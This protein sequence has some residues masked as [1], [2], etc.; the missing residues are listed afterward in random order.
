MIA[1]ILRFY[2]D[3]RGRSG[4]GR[5]PCPGTLGEYL[6]DRR[7]GREFRNHFLVPIT[8]AVWSTA[9]DRILDFPIDY[10]LHFLD[11]H[12][13]IGRHQA[14]QWRTITG[15]SQRYV[16][17]ILATL[18]ADA[19]RAGDPVVTVTRDDAGATVRTRDG[20]DGAVRRGRHGHPRG[21]HAGP[22]RRTRTTQERT[23]LGGFDYTTNEVVLHTDAGML[24]TKRRA[25]AS[26]NVEMPDCRSLG[27]ALTMTYHMNRLQ[28]LPGSVQYYVSVN[29][30]DRVDPA[31]RHH[32]AAH[33]PPDVHLPDARRPA[34]RRRA[35]GPAAHLV[36]RRAPGLRLPRGR[37]PLRLRSPRRRSARTWRG[38]PREI[39]PA[40]RARCATGARG[41]PC[42]RWSTTS[43]TPRWTST[44]CDDVAAL[45]APALAGTGPGLV[46][47]R[48]RDHL[49][50]P[51]TDLR[52]DLLAHLRAEGEDPTGWRILLV[53][54]LRVFG[55]VFNPASFY[56]C[57]DAAGALRVVIIEVHNTHGGRRLYTLRPGAPRRLPPGRDGQGLLRLAVHRHG[58]ALPR[59]WSATSPAGCGSS[60]TRTSTARRCWPRASTLTRLRL[61]DRNLARMLVRYPFVT[62]KTIGMIHWHALRLW[63]RGVTFHHHGEASR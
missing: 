53:T 9:P 19:V 26:W 55:Y 61:T 31:S 37:L 58:R 25:W 50:P 47:L 24:P 4:C 7:Y 21:R 34:G 60:S 22:A 10:L 14:L 12:G 18:P 3:A 45:P 15:G 33:E 29:P 63:R 43:G 54:N 5:R 11:N 20:G 8:A 42:T 56:L 30:G 57:R 2:R 36:R 1:D 46:Q 17:A 16:D 13:L 40:R 35:P 52:A 32:R 62:H 6:D 38:S 23:T 28:S 39:A 41:P 59:A 51:A 48:D 44:S 49:L 27:D